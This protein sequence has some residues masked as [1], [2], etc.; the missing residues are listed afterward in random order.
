MY[1]FIDAETKIP[2]GLDSAELK[3]ISSMGWA[4]LSSSRTPFLGPWALANWSRKRPPKKKKIYSRILQNPKR[5]YSYFLFVIFICSKAAPLL[6]PASATQALIQHEG[7]SLN[8]SLSLSLSCAHAQASLTVAFFVVLQFNIANPTTG[9]QKKLEIDD[10]Q[11]LFV[12]LSLSLSHTQTH[13][14]KIKHFVWVVISFTIWFSFSC[15]ED[16]VSFN[17]WILWINQFWPS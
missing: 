7:F 6:D 2:T 11:K 9:C 4:H 3:I 16:S 13:L 14:Q 10:D 17:C 8:A 1:I 5:H 12:P 15:K